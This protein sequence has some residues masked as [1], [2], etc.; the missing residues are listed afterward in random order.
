MSGRIADVAIHPVHKNTIYVAVALGGVWKTVNEG[1]TWT[2]IFDEQKFYS[3]GCVTSDSK[4][5]HIVWVGRGENVGGRDM[6]YGDGIY[7]SDD[8]GIHWKN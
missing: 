2:P 4:N 6:G 5:P 7:C 3:I 1:T 8:D